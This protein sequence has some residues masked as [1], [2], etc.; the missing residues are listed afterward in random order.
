[1]LYFFFFGGF[2]FPHAKT[3]PDRRFGRR[4]KQ[5]VREKEGGY[6]VMERI[7]LFESDPEDIPLERGGDGCANRWMET[8]MYGEEKG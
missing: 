2:S 4:M 7:L 1:V 5:D 6:L 3:H 8:N